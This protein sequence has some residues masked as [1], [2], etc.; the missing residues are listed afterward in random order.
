MTTATREATKVE[1]PA[2][3]A[4]LTV[5][6]TAPTEQLCAAV[7]GS[8]KLILSALDITLA[9]PLSDRLRKLSTLRKKLTPLQQAIVALVPPA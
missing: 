1:E 8:R 7:H 4:K 2:D 6:G 9:A 5:A 3:D